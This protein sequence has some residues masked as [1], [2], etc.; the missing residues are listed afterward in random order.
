[1]FAVPLLKWDVVKGHIRRRSSVADLC[2]GSE[3]HLSR[4]AF[5]K[6]PI[7][8]VPVRVCMRNGLVLS[9]IIV[10]DDSFNFLLRVGGKV[11]LVWKHGVHEIARV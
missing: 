7:M 4:R 10:A 6:K 2:L 5:V 1:M 9:G 3:P 11:V 8:D